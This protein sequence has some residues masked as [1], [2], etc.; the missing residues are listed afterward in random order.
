MNKTIKKKPLPYANTTIA[1]DDTIAEIKK[2]LKGNGIQD[3]Q[4]TTLGGNSVLRFIFHTENRDVTFEIKPPSIMSMK[5]T[6]NPKLGRYE[7]VNVPMVAQA[8][9]LVYWYLRIKLKAISYGLVS[10]EREFLNQMLTSDS[11]TVGDYLMERLEHDKGQ[12]KLEA[13][14]VMYPVDDSPPKKANNID[15]E[16]KVKES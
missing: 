10:I 16:Y 9:R 4:E 15:V 1:P 13:P 5:K 6:W 12:L 11:R 7:T 3:I 14:E 2:L 8:W